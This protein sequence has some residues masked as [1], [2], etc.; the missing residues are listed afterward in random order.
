MKNNIINVPLYKMVRDD[1]VALFLQQNSDEN[2]IGYLNVRGKT[3]KDLWDELG[4]IPINDNDE[5]LKPFYCFEKGTYRFDIWKW[6]EK[7][8]QISIAEDLM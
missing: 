6:F 2:I 7:T 4:E 3:I 8:F 5:I 1:D